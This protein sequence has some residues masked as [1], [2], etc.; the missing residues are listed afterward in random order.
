M[1]KLGCVAL[2]LFLS[3]GVTGCYQFAAEHPE[4]SKKEFYEDQAIC[5]EKAR[6][7]TIERREDQTY[8]D[9]INHARRC[10][11]DLGW[12]YHFRKKSSE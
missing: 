6:A 8:A 3:L 9:E 1:K 11:R 10:M 7:Y 12:E 2:V 5:E 4:K